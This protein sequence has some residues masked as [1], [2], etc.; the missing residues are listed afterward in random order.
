MKVKILY[1]TLLL[2]LCLIAMPFAVHA[3]GEGGPGS[4]PEKMTLTKEQ[5]VQF[6]KILKDAAPILKEKR[7][8]LRTAE[9]AY[10]RAV[11][12]GSDGQAAKAEAMR[13]Y[14]ALL[15]AET[16]V[17]RELKAAGLPAD[18]PLGK[19]PSSRRGQRPHKTENDQ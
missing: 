8:N 18:M 4:R 3:A 7:K 10:A 5:R 2:A 9:R 1:S 17:R 6:D 15:D 19:R 14:E 16:P 13:A 12:D 11:A